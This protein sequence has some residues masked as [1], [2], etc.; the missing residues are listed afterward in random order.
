MN[1]K[2]KFIEDLDLLYGLP[3]FSTSQIDYV[4][5]DDWYD[6]MLSA[7]VEIN[8]DKYYAEF[9]DI[10]LKDNRKRIYALYKL[11]KERYEYEEYWHKLSEI[12]K[13]HTGNWGY[14]LYIRK[15]NYNEIDF[16]SNNNDGQLIGW[17]KE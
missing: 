16:V 8:S 13:R 10:D 2:P 6:G 15:Q 11:S 7:I 5:I 14:Y 1:K 17:F 12:I 9:V 3:D 4:Y